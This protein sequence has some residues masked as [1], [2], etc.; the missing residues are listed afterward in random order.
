M[1]KTIT[2]HARM[3]AVMWLLRNRCRRDMP[4]SRRPG[5]AATAATAAG[6]RGAARGVIS[7]IG[8][9]KPLTDD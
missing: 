5:A 3:S 7:R 2:R 8:D 9:W 1:A 6:G 4:M